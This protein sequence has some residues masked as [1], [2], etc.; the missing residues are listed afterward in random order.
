[1][2]QRKNFIESKDNVYYQKKSVT[3]CVASLELIRDLTLSQEKILKVN[4]LKKEKS[5]AEKKAKNLDD[6]AIINL[7]PDDSKLRFIPLK[8][9]LVHTLYVSIQ[10]IGEEN[11]KHR[12]AQLVEEITK[13]ELKSDK[14]PSGGDVKTILSFNINDIDR[15]VELNQPNWEKSPYFT[16]VVRETLEK[17]IPETFGD[18]ARVSFEEIEYK[19]PPK[20][21]NKQRKILK[22]HIGKIDMAQFIPK[23]LKR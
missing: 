17:Y 9:G 15:E 7:N 12:E 10:E 8:D 11:N 3:A 19:E 1:M 22:K 14:E 23:G 18:Q 21:S 2:K 13:F 4:V 6:L 20:M 5:E 16:K